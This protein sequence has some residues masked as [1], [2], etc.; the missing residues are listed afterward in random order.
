MVFTI[1]KNVPLPAEGLELNRS[2]K[3]CFHEMEVGDSF[4]ASPDADEETDVTV[5]RNRIYNAAR[6]H[7]IK[8]GK[9]F[10]AKIVKENRNGVEETGVRIWRLEDTKAK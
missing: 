6:A 10:Y 3:Y 9:K 4:F 2:S 1:E 7:G 5:M 8:L